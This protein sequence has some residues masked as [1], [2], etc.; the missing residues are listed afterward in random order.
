MM[1]N[2]V[3]HYDELICAESWLWNEVPAQVK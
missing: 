1:G 2:S 3:Q